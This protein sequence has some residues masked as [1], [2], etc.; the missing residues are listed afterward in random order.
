MATSNFVLNSHPHLDI[1]QVINYTGNLYDAAELRGILINKWQRDGDNRFG[2]GAGEASLLNSVDVLAE[3][4]MKIQFQVICLQEHVEFQQVDG[5]YAYAHSAG[6]LHNGQ[7]N[8]KAFEMGD[9]FYP[10]IIEQFYVAIDRY[11]YFAYWN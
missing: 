6:A 1:R 5:L 10:A 3:I 7:H 9:Q 11:C 8:E 2:K 4:P